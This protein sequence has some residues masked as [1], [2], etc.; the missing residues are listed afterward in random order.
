MHRR[1]QQHFGNGL[2]LLA[3]AFSAGARA[4]PPP[5][6]PPAADRPQAAAFAQLGAGS[7]RARAAAVGVS[8]PWAWRRPMHG[9]YELSAY[10]D[11]ALGRWWGRSPVAGS[12]QANRIGVT[13]TLRWGPS[14]AAGWFVEAGIGANYVTPLWRNDG[15]RFGS[16]FNFGEHLGVG[17][18]WGPRGSHE[19]SLRVEHLSNAGLR[20]PNPGENF[21]QLRWSVALD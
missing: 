18:R 11:F 2:A 13:P 14:G 16:R 9:G 5:A 15:K 21:A 8:W 19:V 7:G 3:L 1:P 6:Q 17:L 20:R 12:T 10:T 4:A